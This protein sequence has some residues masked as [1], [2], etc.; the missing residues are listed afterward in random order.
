MFSSL[1]LVA[2]FSFALPFYAEAQRLPPKCDETLIP[3]IYKYWNENGG[4]PERMIER[5][6]YMARHVRA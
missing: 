1:L 3:K 2:I 4:V 6:S 5:V